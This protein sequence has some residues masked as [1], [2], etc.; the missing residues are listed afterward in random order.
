MLPGITTSND[1]AG[2]GIT[3]VWTYT[4]DILTTDGSDLRLYK[5]DLNGI[6]TAIASSYSIDVANSQVTYPTVESGLAPLG[7]GYLLTIL[8]TEPLTQDVD[9]V[10]QGSLDAEVIEAE[11]DKLTAI[12]QQLQR[13]IDTGL[14]TSGVILQ[15]ASGFSGKSGTNGILGADGASGYSGKSGTSGVSGASNVSGFSGATGDS[16]FSGYSGVSGASLVSG[17][18]GFSGFSGLNGISGVSGASLVSGW[19]GTSGFSGK[20]GTSG[21][22][23]A[24][25][26][27]SGYS[28]ASGVSGT[29]RGSLVTSF[30]AGD[31][32][33]SVS[34][35]LDINHSLGVQYLSIRVFDNNQLEV[36]PDD[37][38][39]TDD[40]NCSICLGTQGT[41]PGTWNVVIQY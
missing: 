6:V 13:Q 41:I 33:T 30:D 36:I 8:R 39:V 27:A 23:G 25:P 15:G 14:S 37:I 10:N 11:F 17:Y 24:N 12:T 7:V 32:S 2:N 20:D 21:F 1:F 26:G 34:G 18:S 40:N 5:T 9:F 16:G 4:F 31:L 3:R 38:V 19:S 22:S 35:W 29:S 28:G